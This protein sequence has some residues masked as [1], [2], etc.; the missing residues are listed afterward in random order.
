[1][2]NLQ[3]ICLTIAVFI[4]FILISGPQK[5][6]AQII[7]R[8]L[9]FGMIHDEVKLLQNFFTELPSIYPEKWVTG[10]FGKFT[11][12][13]VKRFQESIGIESTGVVGPKTREKINRMLLASASEACMSHRSEQA[14]Q[15]SAE[16][17]SQASSQSETAATP[18]TPAT[19]S[20]GQAAIRATSAT[21]A[22][23]A[24]PEPNLTDTIEPATI[25][26]LSTPGSLSLVGAENQYLSLIYSKQNDL[27]IR[28]SMTIEAW[29]KLESEARCGD[30]RNQKSFIVDKSDK[31]QKK[32]SFSLYYRYP[33]GGHDHIKFLLSVDG[34]TSLSPIS[35]I[36]PD[37]KSRVGK[38]RH[39]AAVYNQETQSASF[40]LNGQYI[41]DNG[42]QSLIPRI[43]ANK[44]TLYIGI[45]RGAFSSFDGK[46][47]E[48]RIWNVARTEEEIKNNYKKELNG[49]EIG[50]VGYWK[51][52]NELVDG[53]MKDSSGHNNNLR[54]VNG[55][56]F[57]TDI[58]LL[59][60]QTNPIVPPTLNQQSPTSTPPTATS[61]ATTTNP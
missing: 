21:P 37:S 6:Q 39:L 34:S 50:L 60:S 11:L 30:Y 2:K 27:D 58:P 28:G 45:D 9:S 43:H 15:S 5:I 36:D 33:C 56:S 13:A 44:E 32:M 57:S 20:S 55:A 23:P 7:N 12:A 22:T 53:R 10:F 31:R 52:N 48:V 51:F 1:M 17:A 25:P 16:S 8:T 41:F 42:G 38:W 61:T 46:M 47:D 14:S 24:I 49:D 3:K 29:L 35:V 18:A 4:A 19:P 54:L 26:A 59:S 40:F